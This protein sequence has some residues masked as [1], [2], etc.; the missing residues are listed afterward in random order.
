MKV[1]LLFGGKSF[2]HDISIITANVIYH[3]IKD[4]YEVVLLYVDRKGKLKLPKRMVV[5]DFVAECKQRDFYF[6]NKGIKS[7]F[8]V[9]EIDVIIS[10][11]H[12]LNGEDGVAAMLANVYDIPY[13]GSNSISSGVL[14]DKY[15]T[16][17][18]LRANKIRCLYTKF[19]LKDGV[20]NVD[21]FPKI[22]KPARLGS[23][24][25]ISKVVDKN[26]LNIKTQYGFMF[27][28]KIIT[29]PFIDNFREC[30]QA[31]YKVGDEFYFS[32]I[33]E[34]FK[35]ND[36]L[37]FDD[38]YICSK[39]DKHHQFLN[40]ASLV[41]KISELT[42]KLYNIFELSGIVRVDY[43]LIDG[44]VFVNEINTTP[45]SLAYYLFDEPFEVILDKIIKNA[46]FE[47]QNRRNYVFES[48]VLQQKYTYKK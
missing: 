10:A 26:E 16:Y 13:V 20:V 12:G 11:M 36:I 44:E 39:T 37:S 5:E 15:F 6:V 22:I 48:S 14:M 17:A 31:V 45:G 42:K 9:S 2:E 4:K 19:Y 38:K 47:H 34:V 35:T 32:K 27:D 1:G 25:G 43:M 30:N 3:A 23:S 24:I 29:Q 46:L 41:L 8:K 7:G 18:V 28:D 33:E 40:D 21:K